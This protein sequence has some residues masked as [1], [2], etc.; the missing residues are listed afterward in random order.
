MFKGK[1]LVIIFLYAHMMNEKGSDISF[2]QPSFPPS[3]HSIHP[4][5]WMA[6]PTDIVIPAAFLPS[7]PLQLALS[8]SSATTQ[9]ESAIIP[10]SLTHTHTSFR[11]TESPMLC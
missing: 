10:F 5:T 4:C 8:D 9:V 11:Q 2:I 1:E 7:F 3:I 6:L